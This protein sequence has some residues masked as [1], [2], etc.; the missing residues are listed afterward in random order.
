MEN[1][2]ALADKLFDDDFDFLE[3]LEKE[4]PEKKESHKEEPDKKESGNEDLKDEEIDF[5]FLESTKNDDEDKKLFNDIAKTM[6]SKG[7]FSSVE[8]K[9]DEEIDETMFLELQEKE[10]ES[11]VDDTFKEFFDDLDEDA[12]D[13]LKFKQSGGNT[14]DFFKSVINGAVPQSDIKTEKGQEAM[15]RHYLQTYESKSLDE[16]DDFIEFAKE[17]G[18]LEKYALDHDKKIKEITKENRD[19]IVKRQ[20]QEKQER[21]R[22]TVEYL[23]SIKIVLDKS[24]AVKDFPITSKDKSEIILYLSKATEKNGNSY[25]TKFQS[26]L[27]KA[28]S[29]PEKTLLIAKLLKSDFDFTPVQTKAITKENKKLKD[30][31]QRKS[32]SGELPRTSGNQRKSLADYL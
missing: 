11:R 1:N 14:A 23:D 17:R 28:M 3:P 6:V 22:R 27:H 21:E 5:D 10:I 25:I 30:N 4:E 16:V 19:V 8:L 7:I 18:K 20:E 29:D 32:T 12:R 9:D 26:D 2:K 15:I 24:E 13:F 31:L